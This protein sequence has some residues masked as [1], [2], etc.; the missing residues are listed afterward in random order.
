MDVSAI[1]FE[2][3]DGVGCGVGSAGASWRAVSSAAELLDSVDVC[4][5]QLVLASA[6]MSV[7]NSHV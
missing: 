2:G 6:M 1:S 4:G 7:P 5:A 3:V